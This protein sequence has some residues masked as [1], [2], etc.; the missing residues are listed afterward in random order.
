[1]AG[2]RRFVLGQGQL[3]RRRPFDEVDVDKGAANAED[4]YHYYAGDK[5]VSEPVL[6]T[7]PR[8][9][10][11]FVLPG[12]ASPG[13]AAGSKGEWSLAPSRI[14][15][16]R[17]QHAAEPTLRNALDRRNRHS[18]QRQGAWRADN[19]DFHRV[20]TGRLSQAKRH[21]AVPGVRLRPPQV[22]RYGRRLHEL[23][24]CGSSVRPEPRPCWATG[25]TP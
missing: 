10:A 5:P 15:L 4:H 2:G 3:G 7:R 20:A 23:P 19:L 17:S 11:S 9:I 24:S 14:L 21:G 22:A 8:H 18:G 6:M 16:R 25:R 13:A 1:M 12:R